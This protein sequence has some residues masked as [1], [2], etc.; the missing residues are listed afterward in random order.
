MNKI[1]LAVVAAA[2]A[3]LAGC[4]SSPVTTITSSIPIE[5]GKYS[6]LAEE[7]TGTH[8]EVYWL[9]FSFGM[10]GS[11]Q[12]N[13]YRDAMKQVPG[14]DGHVTMS[15]DSESFILFPFVLPSFYTTRVT[16]TPVKLGHND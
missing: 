3:V 12:R 8:T 6:V 4:I 7:V 11:G 2:A 10:G 1:K 16:G 15:V 5:Q 9:F 13:A 14:A